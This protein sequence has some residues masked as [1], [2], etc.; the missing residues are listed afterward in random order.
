ML[1]SFTGRTCLS[2]KPLTA[3]IYI[4]PS[5]FFEGKLELDFN[6]DLDVSVAMP[7]TPAAQPT[8][9]TRARRR[10]RIEEDSSDDEEDSQPSVVPTPV[11]TVKGRSQR[12]SKTAAMNKM[13]SAIRSPIIDEFEE[14]EEEEEEA[15]NLTS[16]D[17]E[18]SD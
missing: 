7:Q 8:R 3:N 10:V 4:L 9:A 6:L 2:R 15:S 13:S 11:N 16:E 18:E 14:Q 17:S 12:A 1:F 5:Y